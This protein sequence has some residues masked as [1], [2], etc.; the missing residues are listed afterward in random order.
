VWCGEGKCSIGST[1]GQGAIVGTGACGGVYLSAGVWTTNTRAPVVMDNVAISGFEVG[2]SVSQLALENSVISQNLEDGIA[3]DSSYCPG[4][5]ACP[6]RLNIRNSSIVENGGAGILLYFTAYPGRVLLDD[7]EVS[8]N[9]SHG[10][11][12]HHVRMRRATISENAGSGLEVAY[13]GSVKVQDSTVT[14][15]GRHGLFAEFDAASYDRIRALRSTATGNGTGA[16]CGTTETC[17][18]IASATGP[19]VTDLVC[20]K[21]YKFGSGFPGVSWGVCSLD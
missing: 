7:S 15:N 6:A 10:I 1:G 4:G 16:S 8:R 20:D 3:A 13:Y 2:L 19:K 12:G 11:S 14:S 21:S 17:A 18:D 5:Y 9:G